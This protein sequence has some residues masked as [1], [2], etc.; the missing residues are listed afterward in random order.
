VVMLGS[1]LLLLGR[2]Y[3]LRRYVKK[4]YGIKKPVGRVDDDLLKQRWSGVGHSIARFIHRKTDILVITVFLNLQMVA[5]YSVYSLVSSSLNMLITTVATP[6]Q[7][8]FGDIIAKEETAG[9][10][11]NFEAFSTVVHMLAIVL[12]SSA[13]VL[14]LPFMAIYTRHFSD[15]AYIQPLFA[16]LLLTAELIY[17]LRL[18]YDTII[19]AAGKFKDT[20]NA[21]FMEAGLNLAI[22]IV[23]VFSFGIIGVAVGTMLSVM[24]RYIS[25][26][27][28]LHKNVLYIKYSHALRRVAVSAFNLLSI[29]AVTNRAV[30]QYTPASLLEWCGIAAVVTLGAAAVTLGVHWIFFRREVVYFFSNLRRLGNAGKDG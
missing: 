28:Y 25:Y 10:N 2:A 11:R 23:L 3:T 24:Y 30:A 9:L 27:I 4:R 20:R 19:A 22:S 5:V 7:A 12:F 29:L 1:A 26:T 16:L 15:A 18:P 6:V 8:A 14:I 21:A 17:C 13:Y